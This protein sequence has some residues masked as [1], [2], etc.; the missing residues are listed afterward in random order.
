VLAHMQTGFLKLDPNGR[1][2][3]G[4]TWVVAIIAAIYL[5]WL[6]F[7]LYRSTAAFNDLYLTMN[8]NLSGRAGFFIHNYRWICPLVFGGTA[9]LVFVKEFFLQQNWLRLM[10]TIGAASVLGELANGL[11]LLL[12]SP[13]FDQ[14]EKLK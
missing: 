9:I 12:Y 10:I 13:A 4:L 6:G 1:I 5:G 11:A 14:I 7:S 8:A 2:V 3:T